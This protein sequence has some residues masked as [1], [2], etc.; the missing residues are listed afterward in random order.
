MTIAELII[1]LNKFNPNTMVLV[2]GNDMDFS[3]ILKPVKIKVDLNITQDTAG[4]D[5]HLLNSKVDA[6]FIGKNPTPNRITLQ[7]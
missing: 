2:E 3:E 7:Y 5:N 4:N 1:E 6:V